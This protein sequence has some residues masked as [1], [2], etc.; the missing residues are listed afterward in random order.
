MKVYGNAEGLKK[1]LEK[2]YAK[3]I[4]EVRKET[5]AKISEINSEAQKEISQI[6][7]QARTD[8]QA[9]AR[10]ATQRVLNEEKLNAKKKFEEEREKMIQKV[11]EEVRV[12][13]PKVAA[14]K[15]YLAFV[16]KN[17]PKEKGL[18]ILGS[19][20]SYKK[21]YN[22]MKLDKNIVG[23]KFQSSDMV[24]DLSLDGAIEAK[25]DTVRRTITKNLFGE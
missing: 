1:V 4:A 17:S 21:T 2:T 12:Q 15:E 16:K 24:Y 11:F 6:E 8:A 13:A 22:K 9:A 18:E 25:K 23:L 3:K 14:K 19:S 10:E 7:D 5:D 20:T